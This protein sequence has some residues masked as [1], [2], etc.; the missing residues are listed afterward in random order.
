M[1]I[2]SWLRKSAE[3]APTAAAIADASGELTYR[4]LEELS[5]GFAVLLAARGVGRD[6]R[7]VIWS[8]K[9]IE[10]VACMQAVLQLG[11]AYVPL[12]GASPAFRVAK[13]SETVGAALVVVSS[14]LTG[15]LTQAGLARPS[16]TLPAREA[17]PTQAED[18]VV[19]AEIVS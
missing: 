17:L 11:A 9:S 7:V 3:R 5:N 15:A 14:E 13:I 6:D 19:V 8:D 4:D 2:R 12:D 16:W 10:V 1:N 18:E